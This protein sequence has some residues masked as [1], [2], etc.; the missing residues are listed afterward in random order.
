MNR[1]F[2][3]LFFT[4][5]LFLFITDAKSQ[6]L[7]T[8]NAYSGYVNLS[9][10]SGMNLFSGTTRAGGFLPANNIAKW[11]TNNSGWTNT[12]FLS[13]ASEDTNPPIEFAVTT[14]TGVWKSYAGTTHD[15]DILSATVIYLD[16]SQWQLILTAKQVIKDVWF[17]WQ[18]ERAPLDV[19]IANDI[20]YYPYLNGVSQKATNINENWTWWG[21]PYP[22][23][24]FSPLVVMADDDQ[25]RIVAATNWPPRKVIPF[26]GAQRIV[27]K[28]ENENIQPFSSVTYQALINEVEGNAS[29]GRVPWQL[30]LDKYR[31]WLDTKMPPVQYPAWMQRTEGWLNIQLE[32][33]TDFNLAFTEIRALWQQWKEVFPWIQFWGQMS[34]YAGPPSLAVPP[35]LPGE[36]TGCC[37]LEQNMH[38]RYLPKLVE[39][40]KE[41]IN[42]GYH[43][44]YYSA[45][46]HSQFGDPPRLLDTPAGL[47]WLM[48][49]KEKNLNEYF[50]NVFLGDV[51]GAQY[52]GDPATVMNLFDG[53]RIPRN[54]AIEFPVDIY[55]TA[56]VLSGCLWGDNTFRGGPDSIP[57]NSNTTT[58]IRFGRYLLG[59]RIVILG[60]SNTD[61]QFWGPTNNYWT[62]RQ[63]FLLGAKIDVMTPNDNNDPATPNPLLIAIKN[64]RSKVNW[65]E[66]LPRYV[67]TKD[68]SNIPTGVEVRR[69]VDKDSIN[70]FAIDN[71]KERQGLSFSF[72]GRTIAIPHR[73]ISIVSLHPAYVSSDNEQA[74]PPNFQLL[75]NYPNPFNPGTKIEFVLRLPAFVTLKVYNILGEE[76]TTLISEHLGPGSNSIQWNADGIPSGVYFYRL[77]AGLYNETRKLVLLR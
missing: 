36:K 69:F 14:A 18:S 9:A 8:N 19:N 76:I 7:Q 30:A 61:W 33:Y 49:W 74:V 37:R 35:L 23:L 64:E 71:W 31:A 73:N 54:S 2:S 12:N 63:A 68:V 21:L 59:D 72:Q 65:W 41:V 67:D 16:N 3:F 55:P 22:G 45:P 56:Y 42:A 13:L 28:Y 15:D 34:N 1:T 6:W 38:H 52:W 51:L 75:Q 26:Y 46:F 43:A 11:T 47:E 44:G 53:V 17:P 48:S 10:A 77:Q 27:M 24:S 62:E 60:Q 57:E 58:F 50:A 25:A 40:V 66:R 20:F 32:N 29:A 70:L 4:V 5:S 39:F